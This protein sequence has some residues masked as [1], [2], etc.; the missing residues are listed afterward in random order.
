M[1]SLSRLTSAVLTVALH[2]YENDEAA[3]PSASASAQ[4]PVPSVQSNSA[5]QD[6]P[7]LDF[8]P[9]GHDDD[10]DAPIAADPMASL[11]DGAHDE[12]DRMATDLEKDQQNQLFGTGIKEDG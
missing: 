1:G 9:G 8:N 10:N 6:A 5:F 12:D 11:I 2:S 4:I 3:A 7:G